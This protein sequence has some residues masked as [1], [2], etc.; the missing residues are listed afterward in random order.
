MRE[1]SHSLR[2]IA[3]AT[4][5]GRLPITLTGESSSSAAKS[6]ARK[7][8]LTTRTSA[9]RSCSR[10]ARRESS[11][12]RVS[13]RSWLRRNFLS[14]DAEA[15]S[16]FD[17][18]ISVAKLGRVDDSI[19]DAGAGQEIL[20]A[21]FRRSHACSRQR[22]CR[23]RRSF[24]RFSSGRHLCEFIARGSLPRRSSTRRARRAADDNFP[25]ARSSPHCRC[26]ISAPVRPAD[27]RR[28]PPPH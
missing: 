1:L 24:V 28:Q 10:T 20:P 27:G 4:L 11:S 14:Q 22:R 15:G 19:C 16:N 17:Y 9:K 18:R 6:I 2:R 3:A 12:T 8:A 21:R 26:N 23:P 13:E 5:N 7:S 25:R